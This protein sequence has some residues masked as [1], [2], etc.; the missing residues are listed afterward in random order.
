GAEVM[1]ATQTLG[2]LM[3]AGRYDRRSN[4]PMVRTGPDGRFALQSTADNYL[5]VA[6]GDDGYAD[7]SQDEF[8]RSGRLVLKPWGKIDGVVWVGDQ[9]GVDQEIVYNNDISPRGGLHYGLDYGYRTRTDARGRFAFD[10]VVPGRGTA[11]R[12]LNN[13]T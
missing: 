9:P 1:L 5:L 2:F 11:A 4:V 6:A 7:A 3:Q 10:R 13:N 12:V 8:A